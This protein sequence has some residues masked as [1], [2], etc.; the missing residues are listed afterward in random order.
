MLTAMP[1]HEP[2]TTNHQLKYNI[3]P[4]LGELP[5]KIT[6]KEVARHVNCTYGTLNHYANLRV[7]DKARVAG[8]VLH[9]LSL[10][11]S[12]KL[13]RPIS[14]EDLINAEHLKKLKTA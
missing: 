8:D 13:R 4:L 10:Y 7:G 2:R 6:L 9:N 1:N 5:K 11:L 3:K 12:E 14:M